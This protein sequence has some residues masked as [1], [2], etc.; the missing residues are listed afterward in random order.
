[1]RISTLK[2]FSRAGI[3]ALFAMGLTPGP[4]GAASVL[5]QWQCQTMV[6]GSPVNGVYQLEDWR[7]YH[8]TLRHYGLFQ[9]GNG[10]VWEFEVFAGQGGGTGGLWVNGMRHRETYIQLQVGGGGFVIRTEDGAV[11]QVSCA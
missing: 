2:M 11:V 8:N 9:A 3:A 5:G 7:A 4:A 10:A 6:N 1:M